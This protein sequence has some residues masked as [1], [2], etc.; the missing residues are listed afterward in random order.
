MFQTTFD[1]VEKLWS[2]AAVPPLYNPKIS[3]AQVL[4]RTMELQP[5]KIAQ[6]TLYMNLNHICFDVYE[7][8][9]SFQISVNNGVRLSYDELYT[10]SVRAAQNLKNSN[11]KKGDV[12]AIV[13]KN[14][15]ELLPILVALLSLD[16]PINPLDPLFTEEFF[17]HIFSITKPKLVF[18]DLESSRA[19]RKY[20][21]QLNNDAK[22]YT[23]CGQ[24]D[25]SLAVSDL[26]TETGEEVEFM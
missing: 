19:V 9:I 17:L 23:F 26:F 7:S 6:V 2:G 20:L 18:C 3:V 8:L 5:Q 1:E 24:I 21:Q 16:Y 15:H 4:L 10:Q 11:F 25:D 13:S 14:N 12:V 22:I